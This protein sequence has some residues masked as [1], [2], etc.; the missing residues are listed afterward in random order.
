MLQEVFET[1]FAKMPEESGSVAPSASAGGESSNVAFSPD[2]SQ[3]ADELGGQLDELEEQV[4]VVS[5]Y[6]LVHISLHKWAFP[7]LYCE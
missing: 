6:V 4:F 3:E 5:L 7:N 2:Q 1:W